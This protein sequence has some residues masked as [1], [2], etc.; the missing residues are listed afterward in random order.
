MSDI[1]FEAKDIIKAVEF[2]DGGC[3]YCINE[4]LSLIP[5]ELAEQLKILMEKE[6]D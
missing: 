5:S 4:F 2:I 1:K 6:S 3:P